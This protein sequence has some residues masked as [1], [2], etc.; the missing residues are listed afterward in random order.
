MRCR[1]GC[2]EQSMRQK[3]GETKIND[4]TREVIRLQGR[5]FRLTVEGC[6]TSRVRG[7]D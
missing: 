4:E 5:V 3:G 1:G 7:Q 6:P 2:N